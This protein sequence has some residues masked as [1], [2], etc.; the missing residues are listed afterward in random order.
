MADLAKLYSYR[1]MEEVTLLLAQVLTFSRNKEKVSS[2]DI[3]NQFKIS[4][5]EA[6]IIFDWL[7]DGG[8]VEPKISKH[9]IRCGRRYVLNNPLP[10]LVDM[11]RKLGVGERR[12][13]LIMLALEK[14]KIIH[15]KENFEF[16]RRKPMATFNDLVKQ[17]RWVAKKYRGRCEL[18][19]LARILYLDPITAFRLA[20]YGQE[21]LGL[22]WRS[23]PPELR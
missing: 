8:E 2:L 16:E 3:Q 1:P 13:F 14:R 10:D 18:T 19:L 5:P 4:T 20:Q 22:L 17:M 12:T 15:I 9:W 11:G 21:N 6:E 23:R 7:A